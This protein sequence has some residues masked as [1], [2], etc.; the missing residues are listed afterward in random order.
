MF[1]AQLQKSIRTAKIAKLVQQRIQTLGQV[2]VDA[3]NAHAQVRPPLTDV[4]LA[5]AIAAEDVFIFPVLVEEDEQGNAT[6]N[7]TADQIATETPLAMMIAVPSVGEPGRLILVTT[8][9]EEFVGDP[10]NWVGPIGSIISVADLDP[11]TLRLIEAGAD[12]AR[13]VREVYHG[14]PA[15]V[16]P[17][18]AVGDHNALAALAATASVPAHTRELHKSAGQ[19]RHL[20]DNMSFF[21]S[22]YYP[23]HPGPGEGPITMFNMQAAKNQVAQEQQQVDNGRIDTAA[24]RL[25]EAKILALLQGKWGVGGI[26]I[27]DLHE[28]G[29]AK[30]LTAERTVGDIGD[31]IR[32]AGKLFKRVFGPV[33]GQAV[34]VLGDRVADEANPDDAKTFATIVDHFLNRARSPPRGG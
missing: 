30:P 16:Q 26:S 33:F 31:N 27:T 32:Y 18:P 22:L 6:C 15:H 20:Y 5:N 17:Q 9:P 28:P 29:R 25:S 3:I 13:I 19:I 14:K 11:D 21:N 34:T 12:V 2:G 8:H 1:G 7:V 10:K 23:G 24:D 4:T